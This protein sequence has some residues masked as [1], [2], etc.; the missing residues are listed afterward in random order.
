MVDTLT[1]FTSWFAGLLEFSMICDDPQLLI[2][3]SKNDVIVA[4]KMHG[5]LTPNVDYLEHI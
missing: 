4:F 1:V 3:V 5:G 2:V